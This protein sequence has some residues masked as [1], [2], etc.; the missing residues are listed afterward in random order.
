[1]SKPLTEFQKHIYRTRQAQRRKEQELQEYKDKRA[2]RAIEHIE[3]RNKAWGKVLNPE[4][5]DK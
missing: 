1:M 5:E 4:Q 2:D 3:R